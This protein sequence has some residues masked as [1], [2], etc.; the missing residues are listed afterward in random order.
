MR[1]QITGPRI[2]DS[3]DAPLRRVVNIEILATH[4]WTLYVFPRA[5]LSVSVIKQF[6]PTTRM[7]MVGRDIHNVATSCQHVWNRGS[8]GEVHAAQ[9][10]IDDIIKILNRAIIRIFLRLRGSNNAGVTDDNVDTTHCPSGIIDKTF[11]LHGLTDIGDLGINN[12]RPL[13]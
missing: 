1:C 13:P 5:L 11:D 4:W 3:F 12:V 9:V 8:A 7:Y 6:W 2:G 10:D